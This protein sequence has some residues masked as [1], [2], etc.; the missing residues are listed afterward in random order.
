MDFSEVIEQLKILNGH[1]ERM[2][3]GQL[4]IIKSNK[5]LIERIDQLAG[6]VD[7][8]IETDVMLAN[9]AAR[10][11]RLQGLK[12]GDTEAAKR[13]QADRRA[14]DGLL[15][16]LVTG[17]T[18]AA[19]T[20][21]GAL[22]GI[23]L[24]GTRFTDA[25]EGAEQRTVELVRGTI[26]FFG[27]VA[28]MTKTMRAFTGVAA[29]VVAAPLTAI[30]LTSRMFTK[31]GVIAIAIN[32][33]GTRI[34]NFFSGLATR[35]TRLPGVA[36]IGSFLNGFGKVFMSIFRMVRGILGAIIPFAG[37]FG[38]I[39]GV[40]LRTVGRFSG[41]LTIVMIAVDA[42]RGGF[43][44][45][46]ETGTILGA[47][48]GA[49]HGVV[50]GFAQ[51]FA[52]IGV[53][54]GWLTESVVN[55][56]PFFSSE[57]AAG[58]GNAVRGFFDTLSNWVSG[59]G[60]FFADL[61]SDVLNLVINPADQIQQWADDITGFVGRLGDMFSDGFDYVINAAAGTLAGWIRGF[62]ESLPSWAPGRGSLIAAANGLEAMAG[63]GMVSTAVSPG[64]P[65]SRSAD[66]IDMRPTERAQILAVNAPTVNQTNVSTANQSNTVVS[67]LPD[68]R[69]RRWAAIR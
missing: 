38:R 10:R 45:W 52:D 37:I 14:E 60:G 3:A 33:F 7:K 62:A 66:N 36:R 47:I 42:L 24:A 50:Q 4:D 39:A 9:D 18:A 51:M 67:N 11:E 59:I 44:A 49:L 16:T 31:G 54:L 25:L 2:S 5:D 32:G 65:T 41:I 17:I 46:Q 23:A 21:Y 56:L 22:A 63:A 13:N 53:F 20:F 29:A 57:A 64:T 27:T 48:R 1:T 26:G 68:A 43:R 19:A 40:I 12:G 28:L 58:A 30:E 15:T 55:L 8:G 61:T 6:T 34:A 35:F 69:D